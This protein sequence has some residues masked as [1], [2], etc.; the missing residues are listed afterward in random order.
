MANEKL[1]MN[2]GN[3]WLPKNGKEDLKVVQCDLSRILEDAPIVE[4]WIFEKKDAIPAD[5]N[6]DNRTLL[7]EEE[8][9]L[10]KNPDKK[11]ILEGRITTLNNMP[12][13]S[14][15]ERTWNLRKMLETIENTPDNR[16]L[17][18][19][20]TNHCIMWNR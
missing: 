19:I 5:T 1:R 16:K 14:D 10:E 12:A 11:A 9:Y 13:W 4:A 17:M 2:A 18:K 8:E 15:T 3:E 7:P 6:I 20:F